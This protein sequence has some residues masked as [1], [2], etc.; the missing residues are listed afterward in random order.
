MV[1]LSRFDRASL[2]LAP[3]SLSGSRAD[4]V[5][6]A[7]GVPL[8]VQRVGHVRPT[9]RRPKQVIRLLLE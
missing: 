4:R 8:K 5:E 7:V 6:V 9:L 3:V 1:Q 2:T